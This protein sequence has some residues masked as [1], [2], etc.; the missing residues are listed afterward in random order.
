MAYSLSMTSCL[1][2][3]LHVFPHL[4]S[5]RL[6]LCMVYDCAN[7]CVCVLHIRRSMVN[8]FSSGLFVLGN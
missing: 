4:L 5:I 3:V 2:F 6:T 8:E 1:S 7:L